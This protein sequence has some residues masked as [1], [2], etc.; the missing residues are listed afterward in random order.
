[1]FNKSEVAR[2]R[3]WREFRNELESSADPVQDTI[4]LYNTAP[5]VSIAVDPYNIKTW[6][7]PWQ[8]LSENSYCDLGILLGIAYT[9]QL[10]DYFSHTKQIITIN[11]NK[12]VAETKYLLYINKKVIGFD[13]TRWLEV[14]EFDSKNW[15]VESKTLLPLY[16]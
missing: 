5:I 8:L 13:R 1:M 7:D 9:L 2:L 14:D 6:P 4:D 11:T 16:Y 10:T 15:T 3:A 12:K